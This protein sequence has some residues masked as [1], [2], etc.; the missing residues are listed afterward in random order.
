[1][2]AQGRLAHVGMSVE[3]ITRTYDFYHKYF[4]FELLFTDQFDETY[5][6]SAN[7]I[8][9]YAGCVRYSN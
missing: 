9:L 1:M 6:S 8:F 5:I 7:Y 3:S 4:G 2:C